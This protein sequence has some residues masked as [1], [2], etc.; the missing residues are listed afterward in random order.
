MTLTT[1]DGDFPDEGELIIN[2]NAPIALFGTGGV[3]SNDLNYA[4][5]SINTPASYWKDG[6][7]SLVFRHLKSAGFVVDNVTVSFYPDSMSE[8]GNTNDVFFEVNFENRIANTA[9][10]E[11]QLM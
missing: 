7:N 9:Y 5:I 1:Y 6:Q 3:T 10:T 8:I 4:N 2:D 11:A